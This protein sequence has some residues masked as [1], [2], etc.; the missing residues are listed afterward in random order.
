[1]KFNPEQT[2]ANIIEAALRLFYSAT[3]AEV[4]VDE[5][6][7]QAGITKKTLYYHYSDKRTLVAACYQERARRTLALYQSW[8]GDSGDPAARISRIFEGLESHANSPSFHGC[9]FMRA[10]AEVASQPDHPAQAA[11]STYK[12]SLEA[13]LGSVIAEGR[14]ETPGPLARQVLILIDGAL[15]QIMYHRDPLY[16]RD[17]A[18]M[19]RRLL[20]GKP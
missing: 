1:M 13:W 12:K 16:A 2:R 3:I 10:G 6:A 5:I 4:G 15:A 9:G 7:R 19:A 20:S 17:G 11:V 18:E 14:D 8:A